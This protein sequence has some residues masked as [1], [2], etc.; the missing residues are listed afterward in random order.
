MGR[1]HIF[2]YAISLDYTPPQKQVLR[3]YT[4]YYDTAKVVH[5]LQK[6]IGSTVLFMVDIRHHV[7]S[8][9]IGNKSCHFNARAITFTMTSL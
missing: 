3:T 1:G 6:Y 4:N 2:E 9:F 5:Q 7:W 8:P